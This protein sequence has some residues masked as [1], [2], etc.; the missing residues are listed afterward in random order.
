MTHAKTLAAAGIAGL[1][2]LPVAG[3]ANAQSKC[4]SEATVRTGET[5]ADLASRCDVTIAEINDANPGLTS[6]TAT[7]GTVVQLPGA[8]GGWM[9]RARGALDRAGQEI[10]GAAERA[11][12][13][14]SDYLDQNPELKRDLQSFGA[15]VGLPGAEAPAATGPGMVIEPQTVGPNGSVTLTAAGLPGNTLVKIAAGPPEAEYTVIDEATT[16]SDGRLEAPLKIPSWAEAGD[17]VIFVLETKRLRLTS[18]PISVT[19]Q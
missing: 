5:L 7:P 8:L 9:D 10:Q 12:E 11:G 18:D 19:Q 14:V 4:G 6:E 3:P 2:L 17:D 13:S 16:T 15:R 1:L